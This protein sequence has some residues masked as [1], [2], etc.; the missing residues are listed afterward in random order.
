[1]TQARRPEVA[2]VFRKLGGKCY[3][4]I[5]KAQRKVMRRLMACRTPAMGGHRKRC[6]SCDHEEICWNSCRDRHCPKCQA[7]A[8]AEWFEAQEEKLLP[9]PYFHA[10][11]T[12]PEQLRPLA[13]QNKKLFYG[14]L[15]RETSKVL[16]TIAKDP[17]HLGAQAGYLAVLHT[18]GQRMRHHPHI[19]YIIPGGGI[20]SDRSRWIATR[21]TFFLP[22]RVLSRLFRRFFL[23]ALR[24]AFAAGQVEL[25]G[26]LEPLR[27]RARQ[28]ELLD[29]LEHT[30]WVVYIRKPFGGPRQ[31]LKYL[32]RYTHRV[33]ISNQ[34]LLSF[35]GEKVTFRWKDYADGNRQKVMTLRGEEF[36]RRFL[37]HVLPKGFMRIRYY[38][39]LGSRH[40]KENLAL[41]RRLL[42]VPEPIDR[43]SET[44]DAAAQGEPPAIDSTDR[45]PLC[46]QGR[47]QRTWMQ[48]TRIRI[49]PCLTV[50][51]L[52]SS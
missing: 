22:V 17:Q 33:A 11:F 12:L 16:K 35:D 9:V 21:E 18:W 50:P 24:K 52:D 8:S 14:T 5:S 47:M 13:L 39:F 36:I 51:F 29:C 26:K 4:R 38:G 15:F 41:I 3:L 19:H 30:K 2:E 44:A 37:L 46:K 34:R 7:A 45:C 10:V 28:A 31:V 40:G 32:A 20:S 42:G 27:S 23:T 48:R 49:E 43:S 25:F 6:D 1:M